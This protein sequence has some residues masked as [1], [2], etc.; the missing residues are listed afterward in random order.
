MCESEGDEMSAETEIYPVSLGQ[1]EGR[2]E[3]GGKEG[4]P[5]TSMVAAEETVKLQSEA[6]LGPSIN[7]IRQMF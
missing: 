2:E 6:A 3:E 4:R 5:T 7:D 1:T